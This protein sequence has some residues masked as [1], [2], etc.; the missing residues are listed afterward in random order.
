MLQYPCTNVLYY[1]ILDFLPC[2]TPFLIKKVFRTVSDNVIKRICELPM[3]IG[4]LM[5]EKL[6]ILSV[7]AFFAGKSSRS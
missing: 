2:C 6:Q 7:Q 1:L 3:L 5:A 4:L